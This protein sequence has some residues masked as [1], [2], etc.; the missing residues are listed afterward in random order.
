MIRVF[1]NIVEAFFGTPRRVQMT[2][3]L[4]VIGV[5]YFNPGLLQKVIAR[6]LYAVKPVLAPVLQAAIII[7]VIAW[8]VRSVFGSHS[9]GRR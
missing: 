4:A 1:Q 7:A 3:L 8:L 6:I 9:R 5:V 2:A